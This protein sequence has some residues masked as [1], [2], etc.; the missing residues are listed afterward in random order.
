V[1]IKSTGSGGFKKPSLSKLGPIPEHWKET[2]QKAWDQLSPQ[3][4][5]TLA[6][7]VS[8]SNLLVL[9]PDDDGLEIPA[10]L[11]RTAP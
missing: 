1:M 9:P 10:S 3:D 2:Y 6:E 11:R 4:Q 5:E 7:W 8:E